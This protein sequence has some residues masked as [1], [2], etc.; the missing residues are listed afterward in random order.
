MM[1]GTTHANS[2]YIAVQ[3]IIILPASGETFDLVILKGNL[4]SCNNFGV[5]YVKSLLIYSILEK[6]DVLE[7]ASS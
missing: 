5:E 3:L 2:S 7:I 1:H 6:L 4:T